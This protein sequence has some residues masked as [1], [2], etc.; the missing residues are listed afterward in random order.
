M[1]RFFDHWSIIAQD[2]FKQPAK[3]E[4]AEEV[5]LEIKTSVMN[6]LKMSNL[7]KL[8][9]TIAI[10]HTVHNS[11]CPKTR[12]HLFVDAHLLMKVSQWALFRDF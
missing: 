5:N 9:D 6:G 11:T 3:P 4:I 1:N 12:A 10:V 8:G 2:P 7:M